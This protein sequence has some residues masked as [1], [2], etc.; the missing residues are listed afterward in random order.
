[1]I[2]GITSSTGFGFDRVYFSGGKGQ[3]DQSASASGKSAAE[4]ADDKTENSGA[5][6]ELSVDE[7][8]QL[9]QL[10]ATDR[11]VRSHEMAHVSAG[12]ELVKGGASFDYQTGPDG[13]RYA[14]GGEVSI[15]T[16]KGRTPEETIPK[17]QKIRA[18]ALAPADPSPQDNRVAA[19]ATQ[20]EM[21]AYQELAMQ[22]TQASSDVKPSS[23]AETTRN[24][25]NEGAL[26]AYVSAVQSFGFSAQSSGFRAVA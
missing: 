20:M 16:S 13:K 1:M 14:V 7:Q 9:D 21:Q 6:G 22:R 19:L 11:K 4:T 8:R 17:A 10:V 3:T 12:G 2:S 25:R 26:A 24:S 23:G 18:A 15:D 5:R